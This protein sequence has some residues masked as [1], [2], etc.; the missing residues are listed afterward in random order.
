[1]HFLQTARFSISVDK[2][3]IDSQSESL[4]ATQAILMQASIVGQNGQDG[5]NG[6]NGQLYATA[7]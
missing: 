5:Q 2:K 4:T 7:E 3:I 6:Q 1:M